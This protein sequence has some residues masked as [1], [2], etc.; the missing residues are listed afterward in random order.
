MNKYT[1]KYHSPFL[2][3]KYLRDQMDFVLDNHA[4]VSIILLGLFSILAIFLF[5]I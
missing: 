2:E 1:L 5:A 4:H 3:E